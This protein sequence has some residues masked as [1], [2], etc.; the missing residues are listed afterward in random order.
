MVGTFVYCTKCLRRV[1]ALDISNGKT[2]NICL[3][4]VVGCLHQRV[5]NIASVRGEILAPVSLQCSTLPRGALNTCTLF[6][7]V[8]DLFVDERGPGC[9]EPGL[10]PRSTAYFGVC[11]L[12]AVYLSDGFSVSGMCIVLFVRLKVLG[13]EG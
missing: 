7:L 13:G 5:G 10:S 1:S 4:E 6:F 3:V 11:C 12:F 2:V 9:H 8:D